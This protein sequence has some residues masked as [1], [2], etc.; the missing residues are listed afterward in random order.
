M[1]TLSRTPKRDHQRPVRARAVRDLVERANR[2]DVDFGDDRPLARL[3]RVVH[4][5]VAVETVTE[6][7]RVA[8]FVRDEELERGEIEVAADREARLRGVLQAAARATGRRPSANRSRPSRT[9]RP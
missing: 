3:P 1:S 6:A 8:E 4:R 7:E 9:P 5:G 2:P